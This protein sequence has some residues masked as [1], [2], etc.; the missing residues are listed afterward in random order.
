MNIADKI[1]LTRVHANIEGDTFFP[2]IDEGKWQLTHNQDFGVDEKHKYA[3]SFQIWE[4][5]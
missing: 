5:K 4:R 2:A 1:Y 3:Y